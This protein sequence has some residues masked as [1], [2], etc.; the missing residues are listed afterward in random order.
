MVRVNRRKIFNII[1]FA[2]FV[3]IIALKFGPYKNALNDID[4]ANLWWLL[5]LTIAS[6]STYFLT[7]LIYIA[8]APVPLRVRDATLVQLAASF[9]SKI[10]PG[11]W[12]VLP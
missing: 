2:V 8:L 7:G 11:G 12:A 9:M 5:P 6:L 4:I 3:D 1:I 10:V